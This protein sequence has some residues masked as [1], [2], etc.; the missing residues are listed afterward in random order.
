M[1]IGK[2]KIFVEWENEKEGVITIKK[3]KNGTYKKLG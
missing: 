2:T 1:Y 3:L